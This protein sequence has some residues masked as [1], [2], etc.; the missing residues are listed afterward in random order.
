MNLA[1]LVFSELIIGFNLAIL[2]VSE[3]DGLVTGLVSVAIQNGGITEQSP[4]IMLS[5]SQISGGK[6]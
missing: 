4:E 6:S 1:V 5:Y 3:G 2:N